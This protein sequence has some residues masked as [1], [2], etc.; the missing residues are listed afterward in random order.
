MVIIGL[1]TVLV[2]DALVVGNPSEGIVSPTGIGIRPQALYMVPV[3]PRRISKM[4]KIISFLLACLVVLTSCAAPGTVAVKPAKAGLAYV[5]E[6]ADAYAVVFPD[7]LS[8]VEQ[9]E[10]A[11]AKEVVAALPD[12]GR[13]DAAGSWVAISKIC[14][15][16]DKLLKADPKYVPDTEPWATYLRTTALLRKQSLEAFRAKGV[17]PPESRPEA[18]RQ[19][20][21]DGQCFRPGTNLRRVGN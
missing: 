9:A 19:D 14:E 1:I 4:N 20:C 21:P 8:A 18:L 3:K 2:T 17:S 13:V 12:S 6:R 10:Y 15:V 7:S 5:I 11:A 16:H